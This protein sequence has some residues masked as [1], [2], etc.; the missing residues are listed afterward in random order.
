MKRERRARRRHSQFLPHKPAS[1]LR[2]WV[3]EVSMEQGVGRVRDSLSA[4]VQA[5][6]TSPGSGGPEGGS[7]GE[8]AVP[9]SQPPVCADRGREVGG[10]S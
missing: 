2:Q 4:G 3:G 1:W 5:V 6:L 10:W 9:K 8:A 7:A